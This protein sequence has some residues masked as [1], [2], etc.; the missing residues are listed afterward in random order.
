MT[1]SMI[2]GDTKIVGFNAFSL[3]ENVGGLLDEIYVTFKRNCYQ[4]NYLFQ[5]R[6]SNGS[7]IFDEDLQQY[8]FVILPEDTT[9]LSY[10]TYVFDIEVIYEGAT[11]TAM[12]GELELKPEVTFACNEVV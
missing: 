3:S 4:R 9:N 1:I 2:R 5:K 7:V 11:K 8:R 6:L 10:G 12:V